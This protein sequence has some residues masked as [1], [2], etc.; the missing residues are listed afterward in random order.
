[1]YV[2]AI[3]EAFSDS[4]T[5]SKIGLV[6]KFF[7]NLHKQAVLYFQKVVQFSH[8]F[9]LPENICACISNFIQPYAHNHYIFICSAAVDQSLIC[10]NSASMNE[11]MTALLAKYFFPLEKS[12]C[13]IRGQIIPYLLVLSNQVTTNFLFCWTIH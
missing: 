1:M 2:E 8:S 6:V 9:T 10:R 3:N 11:S 5:L 4:S 7:S 12:S 13:T